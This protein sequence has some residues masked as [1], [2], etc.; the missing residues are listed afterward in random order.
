MFMKRKVRIGIVWAMIGVMAGLAGCG[1]GQAEPSS[2][3]QAG[4]ADAGQ[5][6]GQEQPEEQQELK[7]ATADEMPRIVYE[8][9]S[10]AAEAGVYV[11][12]IEDLPDDFIR[13]VDISS[14]LAEEDSVVIEPDLE[15]YI[16]MSTARKRTSSGYWQRTASTT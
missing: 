8:M 7:T 15:K 10:E 1:T 9:P 16:I 14:V 6:A 11:E 4:E 13:G 3:Q 2:S 12:P 5:A